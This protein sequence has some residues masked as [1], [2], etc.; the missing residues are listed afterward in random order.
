MDG[1]V[2]KVIITGK[3]DDNDKT[4]IEARVSSKH[5]KRLRNPY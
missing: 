1:M 3:T 2:T 4:K 5:I